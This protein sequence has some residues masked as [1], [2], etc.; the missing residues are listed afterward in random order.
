MG[1]GRHVHVGDHPTR[2]GFVEASVH[3][4]EFELCAM[5]L[6]EVIGFQLMLDECVDQH[7][8]V[9]VLSGREKT[10]AQHFWTVIK[11]C[12]LHQVSARKDEAPPG[13]G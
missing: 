7:R 10:L 11:A 12:F 5:I 9:P 13:H 4:I 8:A 3:R 1:K 2:T 6:E